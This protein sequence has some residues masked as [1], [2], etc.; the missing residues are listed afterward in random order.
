MLGCREPWI[1][2]YL[3]GRGPWVEIGLGLG[4]GL[5]FRGFCAL[6]WFPW[7]RLGVRGVYVS[8]SEQARLHSAT[9]G[10]KVQPCSHIGVRVYPCRF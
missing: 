5:G 9:T 6:G 8:K 1:H 4:L 3:V 2:V 7:T 10:S